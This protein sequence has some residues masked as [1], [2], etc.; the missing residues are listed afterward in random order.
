L[1]APTAYGSDHHCPNSAAIASH[2]RHERGN[3]AIGYVF[4]YQ[5]WEFFF[6]HVVF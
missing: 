1:N 3:R 2:C 4:F 5:L 6:E